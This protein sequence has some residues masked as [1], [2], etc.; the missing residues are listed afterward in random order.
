MRITLRTIAQFAD[1]LGLHNRDLLDSFYFRCKLLNCTPKTHSVYG[2]RIAYLLQWAVNQ[3][4]DLTTLTKHDIESYLAGLI[5]HLSAVT[6][7]GRITVYRV[8]FGHLK[9]EGFIATNPME[10]IVKL[11]EPKQAKAVI[12]ADDLVRVLNTFDRKTYFGIRN[13]CML[14]LAFDA[15]LRVTE[16]LSIRTK[17]VDLQGGLILVHGKGRKERYAAFSPATAK[18][19]H[20]YITRF[21]QEI[22]GELLFATRD[23]RR[24]LYHQAYR[25]FKRAA[26]KV[27]VQ[28]HPHLARHS[29]A[30]AFVI[31]GGSLAIVQ[32][33]LGHSSLAVTQRYIH[34]GDKDVVE[35]Y[36]RYSPA[37]NIKL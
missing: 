10:G 30:S 16:L 37:A 15:M 2:E 3:R 24:M 11:K 8:L 7:N 17:D 25:V 18:S 22:P 29:G 20:T 28:L 19:L 9:R 31:A 14:L 35:A 34:I 23:G 32:R 4:R 5:D 33:Q 21:R 6:V 26:K 27:G 13:F 36:K 1:S 12:T